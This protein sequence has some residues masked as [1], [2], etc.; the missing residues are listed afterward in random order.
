MCTSFSFDF[1]LLSFFLSFL[2][3]VD[4]E[5][6]RRRNTHT[7]TN[8]TLWSMKLNCILPVLYLLTRASCI[9]DHFQTSPPLGHQ[10][11]FVLAEMQDTVRIEPHRFSQDMK[12]ELSDE[13][14]KKFA[15]KVS[16]G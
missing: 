2:L 5:G 8:R 14:N 10:V 9:D 7:T 6:R 16:Q 4:S 13:L 1:V 3:S 11:M 12:Q 15:N